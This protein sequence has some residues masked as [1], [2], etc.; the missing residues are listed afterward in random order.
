MRLISAVSYI[1][2]IRAIYVL[3]SQSALA[4]PSNVAITS[5]RSLFSSLQNENIGEKKKSQCPL[6]LRDSE[7]PVRQRV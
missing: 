5:D 1:A 6:L 4:S 7:A 2:P 3:Y